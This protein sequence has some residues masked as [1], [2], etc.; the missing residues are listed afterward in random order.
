MMARR[1]CIDCSIVTTGASRCEEHQEKAVSRLKR[2]PSEEKR[3]QARRGTSGWDR[4]RRNDEV[5]K[6]SG[7]RCVLCGRVGTE[8]DHVVPLA[9][10]G[11]DEPGNKRL[12]CRACHRRVGREQF[13]GG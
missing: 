1:I 10:G 12:L 3:R 2:T 11:S 5:K 7:G 4:Q 8:V 13:G 9:R 6:R